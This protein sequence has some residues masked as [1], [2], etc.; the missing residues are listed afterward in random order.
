MGAIPARKTSDWTLPVFTLLLAAALGLLLWLTQYG[1]VGSDEAFYIAEPYRFVQGDCYFVD[2]WNCGQLFSFVLIPLM[3]LYLRLFPSTD[4]VF[5]VFRRAWVLVTA[6]VSALVYLRGRRISPVGAL[7]AALALMLY[8]PLSVRSFS[9]NAMGLHALSAACILAC[10]AD[11]HVFRDL[12]LAGLCLAVLVLCCPFTV[13]LYLLYALAAAICAAL[14]RRGRLPGL[15]EALRPKALLAVTLGAGTL[16][17]LFCAF[18]LRRA[19]LS[20]LLAAFPYVFRDPEHRVESIVWLAKNLIYCSITSAP[21]SRRTLALCAAL[22][23]V[24][25]LDR[26]RLRRR[27]L[28]LTLAAAL[29]AVYCAPFAR[30]NI[31]NELMLPL[32]LLGLCAYALSERRQKKLFWLVFVPGLLYAVCM[33][34]SSSLRYL[35]LC[36]GFAVCL[37]ASAFFLCHV[38]GE[39]RQEK[40]EKPLPRAMSA[41]AVLLIALA[42]PLQL[43]LETR[44]QLTNFFH[45]EG[46]AA[47][48]TRM[49]RGVQQGLVTS[50]RHA[51]EYLALLDDTEDMRR[52]GGDYVLYVSDTVWL[53]LADAKR[54]ANNSLWTNYDKPGPSAELLREYLDVHPEKR[55]VA[56]Y[57]TGTLH[58]TYQPDIDG[59]VIADI[60]NIEGRPVVRTATGYRIDTGAAG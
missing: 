31:C 1:W 33:H 8:A 9:Y 24:I 13:A 28:Y 37:T 19:A 26:G 48:D 3:R 50:S 38:V 6:L 46:F 55:S 44:A 35:A 32:N 34:H 56:I 4:G 20:E 58:Y 22:A 57:V 36:H 60:L 18:V 5:L 41:A 16:F 29:T 21:G 10:T 14:Q 27:G 51:A 59:M 12:Y 52:A 17:V 7:F 43:A 30:N 39:L 2:D 54:S 53:P 11:R 25:L 47:L 40:P 15:F 23:L 45:D 42:L 49:E